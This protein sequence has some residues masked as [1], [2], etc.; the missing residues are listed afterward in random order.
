L[1][2]SVAALIA[3]LLVVWVWLA[4]FNAPPTCFDGVQ[5]G[6]ERGVDCGGS[7]TLICAID[8]RA[9]VVLWSRIF[10]T[11]PGVYTAA[12]YVQN[13]NIGAGAREV[14]YLFQ[15]FDADNSHVMERSGVTDLPPVQTIPIIEHNIVTGTRRATRVLFSFDAV[16]VWSTIQTD[17][18]PRLR[19]AKQVLAPDGSRLSATISNDTV[20]DASHVTVVA[21]LFDVDGIAR[22]ASKSQI[23]YLQHKTSQDVVFT[24]PAGVSD[25]VRAELTILPY[26]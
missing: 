17:T 9:P 14:P 21:V 11:S 24:W 6:A 20:S 18:I 10:E 7:C 2:M 13:A 26:F 8:A 23:E 4:F 15:L 22:A 5:N 12:A 25:I 3:T 1:Y 19:I 16:P